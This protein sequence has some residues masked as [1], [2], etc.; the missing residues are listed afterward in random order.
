MDVLIRSERPADKDAIEKVTAEAFAGKPYSNQTEHLI[1]NALRDA[2]ELALSLVTEI[3]EEVVG[4]IGFSLVTINGTA[5][6]WYGIGPVS[7][8]PEYQRQGIGSKLI[9]AGLAKIREAGAK[10]CV[11][12]GSPE[13]YGRFGFKTYPNL[14]YEGAPAPEYFMA[15]PFY[16]EVPY[17]KVEF[18]KSFYIGPE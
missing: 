17:G 8:A 3:N 16:D 10:G 15:L 13:Y 7:I 6:D 2:G 18:H 5:V 9:K 1:V 11:L 14:M 12:E 4:H